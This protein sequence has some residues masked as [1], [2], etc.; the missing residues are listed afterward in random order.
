MVKRLLLWVLLLVGSIAA[1]AQ[2]LYGYNST[3]NKDNIELFGDVSFGASGPLIHTEYG[4]S[5]TAKGTLSLIPSFGVFFQKHIG[6]RLSARFGFAFGYS[7]NSFK[8]APVFDSLSNA[9]GPTNTKAF[10]SYL[11]ATDGTAFLQPQIDLGYVFGPIKDMYIIEVR[12]GVGLKA[13]L[14][15]SS[16]SV[17]VNSGTVM[18]PKSSFAYK[19]HIYQSAN[20]GNPNYF[21]SFLA[22]IYAGLRWQNTDD[23]FLNHFAIGI[24]ATLPISNTN[25]GYAQL[26]YKNGNSDVFASEKIYLSQF[27]FG[28]TATYSIF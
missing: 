16:D 11:K 1:K 12:G 20:Y 9:T 5:N 6:P 18:A 17:I 10:S 19:Y 21:G 22:N 2:H 3:L 4:T 28:L 8:Y 7:S 27:S 24:Q 26:E 25:A 14:A 13:Y 15:K 23:D